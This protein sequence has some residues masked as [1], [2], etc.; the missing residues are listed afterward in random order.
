METSEMPVGYVTHYYTRLGVAVVKLQGELDVGDTIH[1]D[2]LSTNTIQR[3]DSMQMNHRPIAVGHPGEL[4]AVKVGDR[5]REHDTV[6]K[7]A[8]ESAEGAQ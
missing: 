4:I 5:V 7:L 3:V 1:V 6:Y 8:D 2:G